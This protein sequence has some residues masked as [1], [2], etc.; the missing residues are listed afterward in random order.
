MP[1]NARKE[2]YSRRHRFSER[3]SFGPVLRAPRKLRSR[4]V[5]VHVMPGV[6]PQSRF[7][8]AFTRRLVPSAVDRNT[9]KRMLRETLRRHGMKHSGLD[10]VVTM[11]ER[12]QP[13]Q[14]VEIAA[15]VARMLDRLLP[16]AA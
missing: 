8:L 1:R 3:G 13:G 10:C 12:F 5:V 2:G 14:A 7:G 16:A 11:R 4:L 15:E 9:V 6:G